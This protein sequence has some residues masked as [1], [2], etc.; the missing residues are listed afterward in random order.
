[1]IHYPCLLWAPAG[2]VVAWVALFNH[3]RSSFTLQGIAILEYHSEVGRGLT[4]E[5]QRKAL[6]QPSPRLEGTTKMNQR[7]WTRGSQNFLAKKDQFLSL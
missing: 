5:G 3:P 2:R 4:Q 7:T 1:M 6:S